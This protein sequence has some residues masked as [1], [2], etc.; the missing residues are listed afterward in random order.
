MVRSNRANLIPNLTAIGTSYFDATPK[1]DVEDAE[2][3]L[4]LADRLLFGNTKA[5]S[6]AKIPPEDVGTSAYINEIF[7]TAPPNYVL[8]LHMETRRS[9]DKT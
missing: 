4:R 2:Q 7:P 8:S 9:H 1:T 6:V 5:P 3:M